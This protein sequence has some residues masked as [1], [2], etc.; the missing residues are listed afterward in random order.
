MVTS[1]PRQE[2]ADDGRAPWTSELEVPVLPRELGRADEVPL[3]AA[4]VALPGGGHRSSQAGRD[5]VREPCL[6][7]L[8][9]GPRELECVRQHVLITTGRQTAGKQGPQSEPLSREG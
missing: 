1:T 7:V 5:L 2:C 3:R 9:Q 8:Q 4:L 6:V